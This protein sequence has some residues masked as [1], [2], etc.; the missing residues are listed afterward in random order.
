MGTCTF[1]AELS[2][3]ATEHVEHLDDLLLRRTRL[4]I[5]CERGAIP[6]LPRIRSLTEPYLSWSGERW[7]QEERR[8]ADLWA[9]CYGLPQDTG[10]KDT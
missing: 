8:Y 10:R 4:G 5:L 6:L 1:W 2:W 7:A 9:R 3:C